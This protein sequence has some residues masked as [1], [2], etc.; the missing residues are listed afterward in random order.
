[1]VSESHVCLSVKGNV[2]MVRGTQ[3]NA[4]QSHLVS[5]SGAI[6]SPLPPPSPYLLPRQVSHPG[7][8]IK[9]PL[10]PRHAAPHK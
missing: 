10:P 6:T 1:M 7:G 2:V 5:S 3:H 8:R 4:K 9:T